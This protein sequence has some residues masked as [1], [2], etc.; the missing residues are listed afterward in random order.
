MAGDL[1]G[2]ALHKAELLSGRL[3]EMLSSGQ[4][5]LR[6]RFGVDL[7]LEPELYPTWLVLSA[8]AGALLLPLLLAVSWAAVCGGGLRAGKRRRSPAGRDVRCGDDEE[9]PA[10]ATVV[11]GAKSV[12]AEEQQQQQLKKRSKKKAADKV[13][14]TSQWFDPNEWVSSSLLWPRADDRERPLASSHQSLMCL[15]VTFCLSCGCL[16]VVVF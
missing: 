8:A 9:T 11:G 7:G 12:K 5:Y 2:F 10:K 15:Y 14:R 4:G 16:V 3:R 1:R 13:P 6:A